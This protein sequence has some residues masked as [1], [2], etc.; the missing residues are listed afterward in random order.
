VFVAGAPGV[1]PVGGFGIVGTLGACGGE[2]G[3]V[4]EPCVG[5]F[6]G[7][8]GSVGLDGLPGGAG[9]GGLDG[10]GGAEWDGFP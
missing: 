6:D 8:P 10:F 3:V 2:V 5:A 4:D 9:F 7:F 1:A